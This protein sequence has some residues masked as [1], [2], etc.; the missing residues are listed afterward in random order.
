MHVH[1]VITPGGHIISR[2]VQQLKQHPAA[3]GWT[4]SSCPN[5][6]A[7]LNYFVP[8]LER[9]ERHL[10]FDATPTAAYFSHRETHHD[11][12]QQWWEIA[13]PSVDLRIVTAPLYIDELQQFGPTVYCRPA[14]E[15]SRFELKPSRELLKH[16]RVGVSG[17]VQRETGRKGEKLVAQLAT[18]Q[19]ARQFD[20][21]AS[22]RD[23]PVANQ[24][25]YTDNELPKFYQSLD[26]FLCTSTV[27]GIPMTV[28]EA[29]SCGVPVVIPTNVGMLDEI[30]DTFGIYRYRAGS[31]NDMQ[32]A[33]AAALEDL[34]SII[35]EKLRDVVAE[36]FNEQQ[37]QEDHI[38]AFEHLIYDVPQPASHEPWS[39]ENAGLYMVAFGPPARECAVKAITSFKQ[40][41]DLPVALVSNEPLGPEDIFIQ[42]DDAD[43]G[44]RTAK[45]RVESLAPAHWDYI[46]YLDA[47]TETVADVS[48]LF[49]LLQDG[50][51]FVICK[52]PAKYHSTH[53]MVRPDNRD[54]CDITYE[55]MGGD[56]FLQ[57]NGGVWGYR[58]TPTMHKVMASWFEEWNRWGMRDQQA[59]LRVLYDKRYP[60]PRM[61][62]LGNQWNTVDR[63]VDDP[64]SYTAGIIH[65][66]MTARR[67]SGCTFAR[68]DSQKAWDIAE[69]QSGFKQGEV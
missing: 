63:Y 51:E 40:Y 38:A 37:W 12:K 49:D 10:H 48:L 44:G 14:P 5:P 64:E 3:H 17:Y 50:Y 52:N 30:P 59:L 29:L 60:S 55:I 11:R 61:F 25:F 26:I 45:M 18:S 47:D 42:Q 20:L 66:P 58:R 41:M 22:G 19:F 21:V 39:R 54:E 32:Q 4:V 16:P 46:L 67:A 36:H 13:A 1:V 53:N 23:W 69:Q 35:P 65:R 7:D 6:A 31:Y 15:L 28:L 57:L 34:G 8:Y 56:E 33:L 43:I 9:A 2:I 24:K 62:V 68:L 27:E